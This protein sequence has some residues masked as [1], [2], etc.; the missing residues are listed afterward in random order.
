MVEGENI[1]LNLEFIWIGILGY[2]LSLILWCIF[3]FKDGCLSYLIA[4][5][6]VCG[7][8]ATII[9]V[10][11]SLGEYSNILAIISGIIMIGLFL[12]TCNDNFEKIL[13]IETLK[14][15]GKV[16]L[17]FLFMG[18]FIL[19]ITLRDSDGF[20][21]EVLSTILWPISIIGLLVSFASFNGEE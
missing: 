17:I 11:I 8:V 21:I 10:P 20:W 3:R 9:I 19:S 4:S 15:F 18:L 13:S 12:I 2:V 5:F 1:M 6:G 14:I 16:I 7:S